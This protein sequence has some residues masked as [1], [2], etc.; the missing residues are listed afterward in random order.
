MIRP[1]GWRVVLA[2]ALVAV[3]VGGSCSNGPIATERPVARVDGT[4]RSVI[5]VGETLVGVVA[6]SSDQFELVRIDPERGV[7]EGQLSLPPGC[8][9]TDVFSGLASHGSEVIAGMSCGGSLDLQLYAID[10]STEDAEPF[11]P[12]I[13]GGLADLSA[14]PDGSSVV[15]S[16]SSGICGSIRWI[17]R[18]GEDIRPVLIARDGVSW[19]LADY[20]RLLEVQSRQLEGKDYDP[21]TYVLCDEVGGI[22]AVPSW[23]SSGEIAFLASTAASDLRGFDRLSA[24]YDVWV[25][26]D[27]ER[28]AELLAEGFVEPRS[29][30][31]SPS[32]RCLAVSADPEGDAGVFLI[33]RASGEVRQ[34]IEWAPDYLAWRPD[35][36]SLTL[37]RNSALGRSGAAEVTAV[38]VTC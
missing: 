32:G 10:V 19:T 24:P 7:V 2:V 31:W 23:S 3:S 11:G 21:D 18:E 9:D 13:S 35:G 8:S 15:A 17:D 6:T 14:S 16:E 30:D 20:W 28:T 29:M 33:D 36:R 4:L 37:V 26:G 38:D 12:A 34:V 25:V 1:G 5:W 22:A 27:G